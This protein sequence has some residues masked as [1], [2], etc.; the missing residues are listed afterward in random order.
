MSVGFFETHRDFFAPTSV[1]DT[2]YSLPPANLPDVVADPPRLRRLQGQRPLAR[3]GD[4]RR[5]PRPA[6]L[7]PGRE[8]AGALH[9]RPRHRLPRRQGD[10]VRPRDR[11]DDAHARAGRLHRRQGRRRA[12]QPPRR[13]PDPLRAGRGRGAGL[14]AGLLADAAGPRRGR[15]PARG[16]LRRDD[17]PRRLPAASRRPHRALEVHPPLRRLRAPGARQ[18]RRQRQ[19]G[20]AGRGGLGRAGRA[21]GAALRPRA[22]P[23]EGDNLAAD[24]ARAEVLAEMRG[25]LDAWMRETED[26]LLDGPVAPP[27]GAIVNEQWQVSPDDPPRTVTADPT[28]AP[29]S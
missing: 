11:G 5:P 25:R 26:P 23:G 29:S 12:G 2:L 28:A 1:R 7:R 9:H 13:L 20:P 16:D 18:L 17:L 14:A 15:A 8:H 22:R 27:P 10:P 24:P 6:R 4:R 19:Q 21:R 3:P